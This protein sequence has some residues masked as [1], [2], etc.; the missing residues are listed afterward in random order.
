MKI[1]LIFSLIM[2]HSCDDNGMIPSYGCMDPNAENYDLEAQLDDGSCILDYT[3]TWSND[4][5]PILLNCADCHNLSVSFAVNNN[6]NPEDNEMF[7]RINLDSNDPDFMPQGYD[8]LTSQNI[9]K[10]RIWLLEGAPE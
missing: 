1:L 5:A 8:P 4:I 3:Y 9:E 7:R 2:L 6:L 10:I